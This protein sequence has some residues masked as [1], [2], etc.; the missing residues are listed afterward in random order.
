[1]NIFKL[2]FSCSKKKKGSD[3]TLKESNTETKKC[4]RC[5]IR[6]NIEKNR[7]SYCGSSDFQY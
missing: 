7:C 1:M 5:L 4:L 2:L 3:K 6:V